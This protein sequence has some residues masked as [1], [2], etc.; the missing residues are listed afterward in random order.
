MKNFRI[1]DGDLDL[2]Q[3]KRADLV[4]GRDKLIQDLVLWLLEPLGTG[5]STPGFGSLL[6]SIVTVGTRS[7]REGRFI[8][9][10]FTEDL[11][12]EVEA[13]IDRVLSLYQQNQVQN[14]RAARIAGR[15]YLY[16]K[17]EIL[18]SINGITSSRD[19]DRAIIN[20]DISTGAN[21]DITLLTQADTEEV[22]IAAS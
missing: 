2:G 4:T 17:T 15:L 10:E 19:G 18:D 8:G 21:K 13:E 6:N 11:A 3:S 1:T 22:Q 12:V 5:Y 9:Q 20:V 14:I 16:S 7:R